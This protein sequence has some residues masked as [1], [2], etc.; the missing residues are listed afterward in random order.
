MDSS[1]FLIYRNCGLLLSSLLDICRIQVK[2]KKLTL[3]ASFRCRSH[4]KIHLRFPK[5][6]SISM[7]VLTYNNNNNNSNNNNNNSNNDNNNINSN[8]K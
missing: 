4:T 3:H 2:I 5:S 1:F 7:K 6:E 8:N